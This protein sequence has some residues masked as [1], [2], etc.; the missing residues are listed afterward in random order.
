M[1]K[2]ASTSQSILLVVILSVAVVAIFILFTD[3]ERLRNQLTQSKNIKPRV[4]VRMKETS[5]K[6][7]A[8]EEAKVKEALTKEIT[9]LKE[10]LVQLNGLLN[11]TTQEKQVLQVEKEGLFAELSLI[12]ED[13]RLWEG[14]IDRLDERKMVVERR[15]NGARELAR[16]VRTLRVKAQKEIDETKLALG[17]HGYMTK[18]GKITF[19]RD[20]IVELE[21]IVVIHSRR[22]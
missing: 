4:V 22:K 14:K 12:K 16:R 15:G 9:A 1:F 7:E 20:R 13:L 19:A 2:R 18:E 10:Q 17:N 21:K 8:K 5:A 3:N 6:E 11:Q